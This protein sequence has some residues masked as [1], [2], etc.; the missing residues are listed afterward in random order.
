MT[1]IDV[2]PNHTLALRTN[3]EFPSGRS[4]DPS[5]PLPRFYMDGIWTFDL[6]PAGDGQSRLVA[7]MWGTSHPSALLRPFGMT[8]GDLLHFVMQARQF[9]NLRS[10][11]IA[12]A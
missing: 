8:I 7:R 1:V 3:M 9:H 4:F 11:P 10:R 2:E 6:R 5:E 12:Q